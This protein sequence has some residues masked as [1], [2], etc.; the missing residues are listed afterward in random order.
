MPLVAL[1]L[2]GVL[3]LFAWLIYPAPDP[4]RL[5]VTACDALV[6]DGEP[7]AVRAI[8]E[9]QEAEATFDQYA[10][11]EV[12]FWEEQAGL[13]AAPR[14]K[15][16][17]DEHGVAT[18]TLSL[19]Q[20]NALPFHAR[21]LDVRKKYDTKDRAFVYALPK[22]VPWLLV[23]VEETLADI[24]PGE[25]TATN[26]IGIGVRAGAAAALSQAAAKEMR[27]VYLAAY[28]SQAKDY[29][30]VRGWVEIKGTGPDALP[31]GPVLG[32]VQF[33]SNA[34]N[35]S[36]NNARQA[37]LADLRERFEGPMTAVVRTAETAEQCLQFKIRP[38]AMGG[39]D[40][41][42]AVVRIKSWTELPFALGK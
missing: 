7:A 19:A 16:V 34:R 32:R 22:D 38:I 12:V 37:L 9:P 4:P 14:Q 42:D 30:R 31:R 41:P 13:D 26:P 25:W 24:E 35:V 21:H 39:G 28:G 23:D 2:F 29:R 17:A 3:A 10:G 18:A 33:A 15:A 27:I 36:L 1:V 40:F 20:G 8:L 6:V 11:L 5:T